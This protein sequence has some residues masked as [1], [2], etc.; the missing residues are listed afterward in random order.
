MRRPL[1]GL[2]RGDGKLAGM[3]VRRRNNVAVIPGSRPVTPEATGHC[4]QLSVPQAT[5]RAIADFLGTAS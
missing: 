4:P 2:G 5:A 3:D 1:P